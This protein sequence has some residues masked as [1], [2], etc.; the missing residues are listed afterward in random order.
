MSLDPDDR[1]IDPAPKTERSIAALLSSAFLL[2][3]AADVLIAVLIVHPDLQRSHLQ[4]LR[5]TAFGSAQTVRNTSMR[6]PVSA[7]VVSGAS[8][9]VCFTSKRRAGF[10][11]V[12]S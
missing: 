3:I 8:F 11:S 9:M 10:A 4:S 2:L 12:V 7:S 6:Q 5:P 1:V